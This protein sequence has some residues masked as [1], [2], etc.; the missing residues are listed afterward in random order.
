ETTVDGYPAW[1][2]RS[3]I[4]TYDPRTSYQGDTVQITVVDLDSENAL[5]FFWG[6][7][8]TGDATFTARLDQVVRQLR[9]G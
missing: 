5:A 2:L 1:S 7:A 9:V 8:P 6:S 3:E 4:Q